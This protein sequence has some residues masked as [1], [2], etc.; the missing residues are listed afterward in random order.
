MDF[1][2][3]DENGKW[4][5]NVMGKKPPNRPIGVEERV[6]Y[7]CASCVTPCLDESY[8][9]CQNPDSPLHYNKYEF[10]DTTETCEKFKK[11][12]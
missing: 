2:V 10:V 3:K 5:I 9:A 11:R 4:T 12:K 6:C 7:N 1:I 8:G